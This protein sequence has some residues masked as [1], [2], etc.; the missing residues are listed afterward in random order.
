M[1]LALEYRMTFKGDV[2]VNLVGYRKFG[3][4]EQD[5]PNFTQPEMYS[6]IQKKEPMYLSYANQLVN[7][8]VIS[9]DYLNER[10]HHYTTMLESQWKL[11]QKDNFR[12]EEWDAYGWKAILQ[13][14]S[15][16][17]GVN[18]EILI[19]IGK[20]ITS[21][22]A[23]LQ[24]HKSIKKIYEE[25]H[26]S[27]VEGANIDWATAESLAF[28]TL[29]HEGHSIRMTGEDVERGTFSHRHAVLHDQVIRRKYTRIYAYI[30]VYTHIYVYTRCCTTRLSVGNILGC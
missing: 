27:I 4:N 20:T 29:M 24:A 12:A 16:P 28:A 2:Y 14:E 26:K 18:K 13:S 10:L 22:P 11:A 25:R 5:M 6:L 1:E 8:G 7:E 3:H 21:L 15:N 19:N 30:Y 17:T 9:K 23:N